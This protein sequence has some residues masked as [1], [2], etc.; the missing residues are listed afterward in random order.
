MLNNFGEKVYGCWLIVLFGTNG[1]DAETELMKM[2]ENDVKD[3]WTT[4][5][6]HTFGLRCI[7]ENNKTERAENVNSWEKIL[8]SFLLYFQSNIF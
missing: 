4:S 7:S 2:E 8:S 1:S 3:K 5:C 6:W